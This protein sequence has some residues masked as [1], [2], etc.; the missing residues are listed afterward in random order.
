MNK[1]RQ[2]TSARGETAP[3]HCAC[4][5]LC[6]GCKLNQHFPTWLTFRGESCDVAAAPDETEEKKEV[7]SERKQWV[8]GQGKT[9]NRVGGWGV[10]KLE[11]WGGE[12]RNKECKAAK[13]C[14][15]SCDAGQC[16]VTEP[17]MSLMQHATKVILHKPPFNT[18]L[19]N[20]TQGQRG[21]I[22]PPVL[23]SSPSPPSL[24]SPS[25]PRCTGAVKAR[26]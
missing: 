9:G 7:K 11:R 16:S 3:H 20:T 17:V 22:P 4:V 12:N 5:L 13:F 23:S 26:H 14:C 10:E 24:L 8:S 2:K 15:S 6:R 25:F 1:K 19:Q 18:S 21:A